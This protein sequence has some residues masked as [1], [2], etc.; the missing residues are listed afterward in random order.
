VAP[1]EYLLQSNIRVINHQD[2]TLWIK[3]EESEAARSEPWQREGKHRASTGLSFQHR[4]YSIDLTQEIT[5]SHDLS[6]ARTELSFNHDKRTTSRGKSIPVRQKEMLHLLIDEEEHHYLQ[7][8]DQGTSFTKV[9]L[10]HLFSSREI[11]VR[12]EEADDDEYLVVWSEL[13]T[14]EGVEGSIFTFHIYSPLFIANRTPW[15]L[16]YRLSADEGADNE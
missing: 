3:L 13:S 16:E 6:S 10:D 8:M 15:N 4:P 9:S 12:N 7:I 2:R 11:V 5:S 14:M 1:N